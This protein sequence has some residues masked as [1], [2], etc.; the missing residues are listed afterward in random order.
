V[1]RRR[2]LRPLLLAAVIRSTVTLAFAA[3]RQV[4]RRTTMPDLNKATSLVTDEDTFLEFLQALRDD[5]SA[6]ARSWENVTF[7]TFLEAAVR[8]AED[9]RHAPM[10]GPPSE[11]PWRRCADILRAATLYE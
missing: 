9:S 8:W 10:L 6:N 2:G 11:N 4:V 1:P 5:W 7:D 3:E